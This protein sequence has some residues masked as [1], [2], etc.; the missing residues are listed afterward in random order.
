MTHE[1][2]NHA[3]NQEE[4]RNEGKNEMKRIAKQALEELWRE[5]KFVWLAKDSSGTDAFYLREKATPMQI[6][7]SDLELQRREGKP[8]VMN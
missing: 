1:K 3:E 8:V 7:E 2:G 4:E 6:L 5:G